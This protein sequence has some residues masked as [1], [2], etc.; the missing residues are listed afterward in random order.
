MISIQHLSKRFG[1]LQ[2]LKDVNCEIE[3]GEVISI[4][5]PSGCGK[6]TLLRCVNLLETPTE[7]KIIIDGTE[8]TAKGANVN[9]ARQKTGM[10]FQSF[11][12]YP[13][14]MAAENIMLAPVLLRG[15]KKQDAYD[16]ALRL[17]EMVGLRDKALAFPDELSGGQKQRV[18][19]AR[20]LAMDPEILLMDEPTSALD[21]TMVSEVLS[22][23]RNLAKQGLTMMIVTHEMNFAR[24]VSNRVFYMDGKGIYEE[25]AP[26]ELFEKPKREKTRN[27]IHRIRSFNYEIK[28]ASFDLYAMNGQLE[29]FC[30]KH[31]IAHD[32]VNT[33]ELVLEELTVNGII[34]H[35]AADSIDINISV[36]YSELNGKLRLAADWSGE[37]FN[38][39]ESDELYAVILRKYLTEI[40]FSSN[41]TRCQ[42][43]A[44]V[45][46]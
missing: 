45:R 5:G 33:L 28:T 17:L 7:G 3:K 30:A 37:N 16:N 19:I 4:I 1:D 43:E 34:P 20:T 35:C 13:H 41:G 38:P 24:D 8:I 6:S 12:L 22:V 46:P 18:A 23:I 26:G 10:V 31:A 9:L 14:L 2:V 39:L 27:F 21:P 40:T 25:G 15:E 36:G 44:M 11:N 42:L 29:V 32:C